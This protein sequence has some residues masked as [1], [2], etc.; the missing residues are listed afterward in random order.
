[1]PKMN[2]AIKYR[3][4]AMIETF[5]EAAYLEATVLTRKKPKC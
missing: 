5:D 2:A 1:M 3:E 4:P